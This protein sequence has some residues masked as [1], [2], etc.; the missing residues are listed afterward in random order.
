MGKTPHLG[1][2]SVRQ[3]RQH[4]SLFETCMLTAPCIEQPGGALSEN[5]LH[6][7]SASWTPAK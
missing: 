3:E 4:M 6:T 7:A 2:V 1:A 5:V